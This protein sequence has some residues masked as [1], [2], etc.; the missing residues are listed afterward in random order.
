VNTILKAREANLKVGVTVEV[1]M[2]NAQK[3]EVV[4]PACTL[5]R[6]INLKTSTVPLQSGVRG[7]VP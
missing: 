6:S 3:G 2:G 1:F 5:N 7:H 4:G